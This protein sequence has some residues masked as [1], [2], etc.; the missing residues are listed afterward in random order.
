MG[1]LAP[2]IPR[3][4]TP[5]LTDHTVRLVPWHHPQPPSASPD[6]HRQ[7]RAHR[8]RALTHN[9]YNISPAAADK[10]VCQ[11][12]FREVVAVD[13]RRRSTKRAPLVTHPN[14]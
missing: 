4:V 10:M 7:Q 9:R 13:H 12:H 3:Y 2:F 6:A 14:A 11:R 8:P 5:I 1:F